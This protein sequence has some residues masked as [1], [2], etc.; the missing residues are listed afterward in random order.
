MANPT[1]RALYTRGCR[2]MFS[3]AEFGTK[4]VPVCLPRRQ[5]EDNK[6]TMKT[7]NNVCDAQSAGISLEQC[8]P[9]SCLRIQ[10]SYHHPFHLV[11]QRAVVVRKYCINSSRTHQ[12]ARLFR[13]RF[14]HTF[15]RNKQTNFVYTPSAS[16]YKKKH[17][18][19]NT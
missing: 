11:S 4:S 6:K 14:L 17:T 5:H 15:P 10:K 19:T 18:P 8:V 9:C 16:T 13:S 3:M 12:R 2:K 7:T 1:Q